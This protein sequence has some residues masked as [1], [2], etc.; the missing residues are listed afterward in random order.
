MP[1]Q[2]E[3]E[4]NIKDTMSENIQYGIFLQRRRAKVRVC[5]RPWRPLT[6]PE[7]AFGHFR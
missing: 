4:L 5:P 6:I 1:V 7:C 2:L 3:R